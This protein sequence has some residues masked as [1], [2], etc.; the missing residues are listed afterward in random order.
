M[1]LLI[2]CPPPFQKEGEP[3]FWKFQKGGEPEK[4]F[5]VG[6][7]KRGK[8]FQKKEETQLLNFNLGLEKDKKCDF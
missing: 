5:G 4:T 3:K 7:T 8:D 2:V 1:H 6:E